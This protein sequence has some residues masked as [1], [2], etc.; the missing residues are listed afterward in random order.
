M[1][2]EDRIMPLNDV[3]NFR[4][5]GGLVIEDGRCTKKHIYYRSDSLHTFSKNDIDKLKRLNIKSIIDLRTPNERAGKITAAFNSMDVKIINI[6]I[7]PLPNK[8]DPSMLQ[9]LYDVVRGRY[10]NLD[11]EGFMH[12][13]YIRMATD[14]GQEINKIFTHLADE[15][16][17]PVLIHC[18]AGKDRTGWVSYLLHSIARVPKDFI[19][20]DYLLTN[21]FSLDEAV[22]KKHKKMLAIFMLGKFDANTFRP[23]QEA[24][25]D[26]LKSAE[27]ALYKNYNTVDEYLTKHCN[28]PHAVLENIRKILLKTR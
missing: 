19:Y 9:R 26:Y 10:R 3:H 15:R 11:F 18:T 20:E 4:D 1:K 14:H 16:N 13:V 25:I 22:M 21:R 2:I 17:M 7:Y 5:V 23:M 8:K 27:D 24:R 6:P 12:D 28:V